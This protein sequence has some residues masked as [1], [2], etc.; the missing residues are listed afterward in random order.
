MKPD[1]LL[2]TL[3]AAG[4][5][6]RPD[7]VNLRLRPRPAQ[8]IRE[9]VREHKATLLAELRREVVEQVVGTYE[10]LTA[11]AGPDESWQRTL[12]RL[13]PDGAWLRALRE[14][15]A[16]LD[17]GVRAYLEGATDRAGL[18]AVLFAYESAWATAAGLTRHPRA[19]ECSLDT[20]DVVRREADGA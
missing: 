6:V 16:A 11:R 12:A 10:R 5:E 4:V 15:D 2:A 14:A 18:T 20:G 17:A 9:L 7:G 8:E 1:E 19:A 13:R 3:R